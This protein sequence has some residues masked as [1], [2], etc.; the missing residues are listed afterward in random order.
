MSDEPVHRCCTDLFPGCARGLMDNAIRCPDALWVCSD[1]G[2]RVLHED[3]V[4]GK[5]A[6]GPDEMSDEHDGNVCLEQRGLRRGV[7]DGQSNRTRRD[8]EG[9]DCAGTVF[10]DGPSNDKSFNL[11]RGVSEFSSGIDS[12]LCRLEVHHG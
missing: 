3:L 4:R 8:D 11:K 7:G 1:I 2:I 12:L 9:G 6:G 5:G 10:M